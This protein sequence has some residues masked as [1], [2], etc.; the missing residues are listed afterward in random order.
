MTGRLTA[1]PPSHPAPLFPG[2][3]HGRPLLIV[4]NARRDPE[5]AEIRALRANSCSRLP[6]GFV[7]IVLQ[8]PL[9]ERHEA[10]AASP[11]SR[12][13]RGGQGV[14]AISQALHV[15]AQALHVTAQA[16]HVTA[17]ALHVTAQALHV[18][19]QALHVTP[20]ALHV[21]GAS[22]WYPARELKVLH[23]YVPLGS[24]KSSARHP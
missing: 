7:S 23:R 9:L 14:R 5:Q 22:F 21:T 18:T 6:P 3:L 15:T 19:P 8:T 24:T 10:L 1:F 13:G 11:L 4:H 12:S 20:R 17:Q 16:L 2:H